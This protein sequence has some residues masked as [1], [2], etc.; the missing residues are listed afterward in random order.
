MSI[1]TLLCCVVANNIVSLTIVKE[2]VSSVLREMDNTD[3]N[4][5]VQSLPLEIID[6]FEVPKMTYDPD[7]KHFL[8]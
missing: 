2:A 6:I 3:D 4:G 7:R 5:D 8:A 1:H